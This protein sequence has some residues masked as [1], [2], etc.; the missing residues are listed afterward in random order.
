MNF[1]RQMVGIPFNDS[2]EFWLMSVTVN[3]ATALVSTYIYHQGEPLKY[4]AEY[5]L[6]AWV[7]IGGQWWNN[8]PP[9]GKGVSFNGLRA[10][11][12]RFPANLGQLETERKCHRTPVE[13]GSSPTWY[14]PGWL[15][16]SR[17]WCLDRYG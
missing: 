7:L 6:E 2:L 10:A 15:W 5:E 4:W 9:V 14:V 1:L 17:R 8:V 13:A 3:G 16:L 11:Y 12:S